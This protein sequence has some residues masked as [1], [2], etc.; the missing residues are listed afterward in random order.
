[1]KKRDDWRR[2]VKEEEEEDV[3][4]ERCRAQHPHAFSGTATRNPLVFLALRVPLTR[5]ALPPL[6]DYLFSSTARVYGDVLVR[7]KVYYG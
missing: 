4:E 2:M 5:C 7:M 1:M 3:G 6:E